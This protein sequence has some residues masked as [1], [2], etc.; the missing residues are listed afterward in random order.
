VKS[1]NKRAAAAPARNKSKFV[2][3]TFSKTPIFLRKSIFAKK[4][5]SLAKAMFRMAL[6]AIHLI[7][8]GAPPPRRTPPRENLDNS[9]FWFVDKL[10]GTVLL[11]KRTV[12]FWK[13]RT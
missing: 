13:N 11:A 3:V 7:R 12:P 2:F 9:Y 10:K 4:V 6:G 1:T 5:A 8:G